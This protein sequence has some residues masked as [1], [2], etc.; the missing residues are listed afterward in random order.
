MCTCIVTSRYRD[1]KYLMPFPALSI[2]TDLQEY[3]PL[4]H[5]RSDLPY[6]SPSTRAGSLGGGVVNQ[7]AIGR[8]QTKL[9]RERELEASSHVGSALQYIG[10]DLVGQGA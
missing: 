10:P 7:E 5:C 8:K 6:S 1:L 4:V 9:A 2:S 3:T